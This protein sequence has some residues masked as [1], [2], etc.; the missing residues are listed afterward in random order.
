MRKNKYQAP[1]TAIP[2]RDG[3]TSET[4]KRRT[5]VAF[6]TFKRFKTGEDRETPTRRG[7]TRRRFLLLYVSASTNM[8]HVKLHRATRRRHDARFPVPAA[9]GAATNAVARRAP[10]GAASL[11]E[12]AEIERRPAAGAVG[13]AVGTEAAVGAAK[14][15]PP[16]LIRLPDSRT[17]GRKGGTFMT[18]PWE[19]HKQLL[20]PV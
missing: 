17:V 8:K 4:R 9:A 2:Y 6:E 14:W 11:G 12:A 18:R 1:R 15:R 20:G 13:D 10:A 5:S 19:W 3:R 16:P 7:S